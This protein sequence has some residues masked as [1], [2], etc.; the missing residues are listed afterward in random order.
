M[1]AG[2]LGIRSLAA[3]SSSSSR[4]RSARY[5]ITAG[6]RTYS[7]AADERPLAGIKVVDLTRVLAGPTATMMLVGT[8]NDG[9]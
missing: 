7:V 9:R 3:A 1:F 2:T 6:R 5:V 4:L 8:E